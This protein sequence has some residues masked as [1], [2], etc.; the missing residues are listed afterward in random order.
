[1]FKVEQLLQRSVE[2]RDNADTDIKERQQITN[3]YHTNGDWPPGTN[4]EGESDDWIYE[5][6]WQDTAVYKG[7]V[8]G[9]WTS[10]FN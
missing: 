1:M 9:Q 4:Y 8:I 5:N 6:S 7:D 3:T 2:D 10:W